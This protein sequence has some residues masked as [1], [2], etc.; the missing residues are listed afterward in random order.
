MSSND[1][2]CARLGAG[3]GAHRLAHPHTTQHPLFGMRRYRFL[4]GGMVFLVVGD[5]AVAG[6]P[7]KFRSFV[8]DPRHQLPQGQLCSNKRIE[9]YGVSNSTFGPKSFVNFLRATKS[10]RNQVFV[11]QIGSSYCFPGVPRAPGTF[12]R[13]SL[14]AH[15]AQGAP[16]E[17]LHGLGRPRKKPGEKI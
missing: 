3:P 12:S 14:G 9:P 8:F 4:L 10:A 1:T 5:R 2:A 17:G 11:P 16:G 15:G 13:S 6:R 7:Q